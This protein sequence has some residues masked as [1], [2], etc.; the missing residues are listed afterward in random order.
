MR[1]KKFEE[2][3]I[4]LDKVL[5]PKNEQKQKNKVERQQ[6]NTKQRQVVTEKVQEAKPCDVTTVEERRGGVNVFDHINRHNFLSDV[7]PGEQS[8]KQIST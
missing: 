4:F 7:Q 3:Q 8:H 6:M 2:F 5:E 1:M